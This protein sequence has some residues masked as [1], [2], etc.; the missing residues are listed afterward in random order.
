M[1][2][3]A[4]AG[5]GAGARA[6]GRGRGRWGRAEP[7]TAPGPSLAPPRAAHTAGG[8]GAGAPAAS[9]SSASPGTARGRAARAAGARQAE[10]QAGHGHHQHHG[11]HPAAAP[12]QRRAAAHRPG[13]RGGPAGVAPSPP[14]P[15]PCAIRAGAGTRGTGCGGGR[16]LRGGGDPPVIVRAPS[17]AGRP[18]PACPPSPHPGSA[19]AAPGGGLRAPTCARACLAL[20]PATAAPDPGR[21]CAGHWAIPSP[22]A[23]CSACGHGCRWGRTAVLRRSRG[24]CVLRAWHRMPHG[25]AGWTYLVESALDPRAWRGGGRLRALRPAPRD[26]WR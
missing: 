12:Q 13:T 14:P 10:R 15:R 6:R 16:P 21:A 23:T 22:E 20:L 19:R 2:G 26:S 24:A 9:P 17:R 25:E 3:G 8:Q 1:A 11:L 18:S 4:G 5:R 7:V